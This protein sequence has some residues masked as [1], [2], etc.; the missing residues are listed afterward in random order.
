M[1]A[2]T[3]KQN[4][5]FIK[6]LMYLLKFNLQILHHSGKSHTVPDALSQLFSRNIMNASKDTFD[7]EIFHTFAR[8]T[9]T[10]SEDFHIKLQKV[11]KKDKV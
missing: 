5:Q 1:T 8:F 11:Y 10:M 4:F 2:D 3:V 9:I 6:T 7:I